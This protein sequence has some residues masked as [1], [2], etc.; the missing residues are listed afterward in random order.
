MFC[1]V[2]D[3]HA[4]QSYYRCA[5]QA[6]EINVRKM[7]REDEERCWRAVLCRGMGKERPPRAPGVWGFRCCEE[8]ER[9]ERAKLQRMWTNVIA[10]W[11]EQYHEFDPI[12][13]EVEEARWQRWKRKREDR[14]SAKSE[15]RPIRFFR[16]LSGAC[17]G[18]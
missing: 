11:M 10:R 18:L 17:T 6:R 14:E 1:D 16:G 4:E 8:T 5:L 15:W 9:H 3:F 7:M 12:P 2:E 13:P